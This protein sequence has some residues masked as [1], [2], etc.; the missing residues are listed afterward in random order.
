M[1]DLAIVNGIIVDPVSKRLV[2]GNIY[3]NKGKIVDIS[4]TTHR[5][6]T[7][8]DAQGCYV[9]PGFIDIHGH[10]DGHYKS[11]ELLAQQGVTTVLNGNCGHGQV[12]FPRFFADNN[13][14]ILNQA[15]L[16]GATTLREKVGVEDPY[17]ALTTEQIRRAQELL[18]EDFANGAIG[19]SFGLEYVPGTSTEELLMLSKV[20]AKYDKFISVHVRTDCE[21][22]LQALREM[23]DISEQTGAAV[24]ISHVVYQFGFGMMR[25][26]LELIDDA[27]ERGI[28]ISC[29]SGLYTSFVTSVGSAVFDEGCLEKWH[30]GYEDLMPAGGK[31]R[32]KRLTKDMFDELRT[33]YPKDSLIALIGNENEIYEAFELPYMMV[34]SDAGVAEMNG[35]SV[36]EGHP[37]DAGTFPKF[38]HDLVVKRKQ[39]SLPEAIAR[40]TTL[41]ATRIGLKDKG[42][43]EIGADADLA[44]FNLTNILDNSRF[45]HLGTP[46]ALPDGISH[47]II[48]GEIA[49]HN[50]KLVNDMAGVAIKDSC[51]EWHFRGGQT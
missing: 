5:A 2:A 26:A 24:Q 34:S 13:K 10:I 20:V 48:N 42:K 51:N 4:R 16:S 49:I 8:V 46:T 27:I 9:S 22:G 39:L 32:G 35:L 6:A 14:F 40:I 23:F 17:V 25:L 33:D 44:V 50:K 29:D 18:E 45:P 37:Q 43:I 15:M 21:A 28:D 31:Y 30:C 3:C 38:I 12:D 41:P 1:F 47:V 11:G 36:S 7:E 19:L